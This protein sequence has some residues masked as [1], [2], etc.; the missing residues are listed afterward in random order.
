M[1][2]GWVGI[3]TIWVGNATI[4]IFRWVFY[5]TASTEDSP[6]HAR[7]TYRDNAKALTKITNSLRCNFGMGIHPRVNPWFSVLT[8]QTSHETHLHLLSALA[9]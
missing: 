5:V 1:P 2:T 4:F 8:E 7:G 9:C 6:V 3:H